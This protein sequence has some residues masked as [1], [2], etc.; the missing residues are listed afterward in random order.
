M[1]NMDLTDSEV[2]LVLRSR[3]SPAE[4]RNEDAAQRAAQEQAMLDRMTAAERDYYTK[5]KAV[6]DKLTPPQKTAAQFL[7]VAKTAA[8][9]LA[10]PEVA[11]QVE[12]VKVLL[13][14]LKQTV[15]AT[16]APVVKKEGKY[17]R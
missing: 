10:R 6:V 3:R 4:R 5:R 12:A 16:P 1:P 17:V 8:A 11:A 14:D 9:Q 2:N 13:P 15:T 7:G